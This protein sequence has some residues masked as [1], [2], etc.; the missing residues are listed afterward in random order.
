MSA[1][2]SGGWVL[3]YPPDDPESV[4]TVDAHFMHRRRETVD[5]QLMQWRREGKVS[6]LDI[7]PALDAAFIEEFVGGLFELSAP[8]QKWKQVRA[9]DSAEAC[10]RYKVDLRRTLGEAHESLTPELEPFTHMNDPASLLWIGIPRIKAS[11][12]V[13]TSAMYPPAKAE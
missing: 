4:A 13:P 12:C 6:E 5:A 3:A 8:I 10:E 1:D 2:E 7:D 11:R 9:F